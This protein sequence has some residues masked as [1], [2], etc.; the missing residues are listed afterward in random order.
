M[1]NPDAA[2]NLLAVR[3]GGESRVKFANDP[4]GREFDVVSDEYI[5]QVKPDLSTY[6]KS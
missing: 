6:G 1:D 3:I 2:A 4:D 5:A